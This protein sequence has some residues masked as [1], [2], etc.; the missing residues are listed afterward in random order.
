[1]TRNKKLGVG[2]L[3]AAAL[4]GAIYF[5]VRANPELEVERRGGTLRAILRDEPT[6]FNRYLGPADNSKELL[7]QVLHDRLV[8]VNRA[9]DALEPRLAERWTAEPDGVTHTI[10]LRPGVTF[11]DGAPFTSAD[12]LF[13]FEAVYSK[14]ANSAI[15]T[16][17][18]IGGKPLEV[19]APD[20]ATVRIRFPSPFGPGVRVLDNLP[21][22]P[23]HKLEP[24]LR[25]GTFKEAWGLTTPAAEMP[26]LG[27]F[28]I[29]SYL[30]GRTLTLARN[31]RY[32]KKDDRGRQL[33]YLDRLE[34]QIVADMNVEILQL[35]SGAVDLMFSDLRPEDY[36]SLRR[37]EGQGRVRLVDAGISLDPPMFW[38]NLDP[39]AK[40][41][42]PRRGWLQATDFRRALSHAIDRE[43]IVKTLYL[44]AAVPAFGPVTPANQTWYVSDLPRY[45]Y[46]PAAARARLFDL[47]LTDSNGDDLLEDKAGQPV[48]FSIVTNRGNTIRERT[49]AVMQEQFRK[50]GVTMDVVMLERGAL[51]QR[52]I[53]KDY[54]TVYFGTE[55]T[56]RDP[57]SNLDF[58]TS[59]G[60]FHVWNMG[61]AKPATDWERRIDELM[62]Q[63]VAASDLAERQRLFAEVQRI[64]A[65]NIPVIYVTAPRVTVAL[66]PRVLNATPAPIRPTVLWNSESLAVRP[67]GS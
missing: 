59:S 63:Q 36:A 3:A 66:G 37:L 35:E 41:S 25:N 53:S 60:G 10:S 1:M 31:P 56:S 22:L 27:P 67:E 20:A 65:E 57:S 54:D 29:E 6:G 5:A 13:A 28:V 26:G 16:S 58:W 18:T 8:R 15:G 24:A 51:I 55:S 12:V 49:V 48:R 46:D 7:A 45:G 9:T 38:F 21:I 39:A 17:L 4:A 44:G 61:Q 34:F 32:W 19:T 52:I 43:A 47:G 40:A 14:A 23:R 64:F 50:I 11:S 42:D 33:P 2:A 62:V 30:P